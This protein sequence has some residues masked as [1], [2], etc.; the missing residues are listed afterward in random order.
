VF[1]TPGVSR[2]SAPPRSPTSRKEERE[3]TKRLRRAGAGKTNGRRSYAYRRA[4]DRRRTQAAC[5]T[6]HPLS[7]VL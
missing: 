5:L 1:A 7:S 6:I 4:E 3:G 2:R